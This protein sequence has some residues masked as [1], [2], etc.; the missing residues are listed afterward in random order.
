MANKVTGANAGGPR[1]LPIR[2]YWAARIAQFCRSLTMKRL[3]SL[4]LLFIAPLFGSA[5][6]PTMLTNP[7]SA[8]RAVLP[9]GW[10]ILKVEDNTYPFYRPKGNGK[11]VFLGISE[12]KYLKEHFSAVLYIMPLDYQDG[13]DDPTHGKAASWPARLIATTKTAKLYLW[14]GSQAEDWK[15]M[16]EDL[17][18]ALAR[19]SDQGGPANRSQPVR[20]ETNRTSS[21]AGSRR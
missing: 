1:R 16:Q 5:Q 10:T 8:I 17:L 18:K 7:V 20:S 13:G 21:A 9:H 4:V 3:L 19:N 15:T 6:T 14:P 12:K 2:G 11:A